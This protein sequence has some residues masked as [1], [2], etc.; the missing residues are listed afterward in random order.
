[1]V[2]TGKPSKGCQMCRMRR[3]KCDETKPACSQCTKSRRECPGYKDEFDLM[4]R[5]ETRATERRA[6]KA[7]RKGSTSTASSSSTSASSRVT[8]KDGA[9]PPNSAGSSSSGDARGR[10]NFQRSPFEMAVIPAIRIPTDTKA[11]CHFVSNFVLLPRPGGTRGFM[12]FLIPLMKKDGKTA[13]LQHAFNACALSSLGNRVSSDGVDFP[14]QAFGEYVKALRAT[15]LAIKDPQTSTS[16]SLLAAVLLLSMF[17]N[18]TASK[19]GEYAW[20]SHV[21][22]AI[23][24]VKARGRKQL[25]TPIGL[26]LFVAV[27]IALIIHTLSSGEAPAMGVDWWFHDAIHDESAAACQRLSLMASEL[28]A[29]VTNIM[30]TLTR[31]PENIEL[32]LALMRRAQ[33]V[34]REIAEWMRT[35]P[36]NWRSKTLCWQPPLPP[37]ADYAKAE[38]YPGRVD[39][40]HDFW[41]A[42]VWNN[43]RTARLI[44]MS[45]TVRCA[46]WACSPVDYRT[47]PEYAGAARIA[48]DM[49]TDI[50]ASIPYHLGWHIKRKQVFGVQDETSFAC[51]EDD[52]MKGLAGYFLTWPLA[53]TMIQDYLTDNQRR[54]VQ[55]RLK[56]I[57]DE[58][59]VRYAHILAQLQVRIPSMLI[60]RDGLMANPYQVGKNFEKL[61]SAR[62]AA[63]TPGYAL[64][65]L[66]QREAMHKEDVDKRRAELI[67]RATGAAGEEVRRVAKKWLTM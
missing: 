2:Y 41:M 44:L 14:E 30:I 6:Q 57:G 23:Q 7:S 52:G 66:Q 29:E 13:H 5:N 1:M 8:D 50:L 22:G 63:P 56:Y 47:T 55:G 39:V 16:D 31:T 54:W 40:Y 33:S 36:G 34:D 61:L 64:N 25:R 27:R 38:V 65:P 28:R 62:H 45:L 48:I 60:R 15:N 35:L 12:D 4:L 21:D 11:Q 19:N 67:A 43:A 3:I 32:I 59:G 51:G 24:L 9:E 37:D 49:I 42:S 58:L 17:E 46:A 10:F 26:Q 18:I 53:C 20:G